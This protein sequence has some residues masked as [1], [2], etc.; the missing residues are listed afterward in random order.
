MG[1]WFEMWGLR[2]SVIDVVIVEM[3]IY[4]ACDW[5]HPYKSSLGDYK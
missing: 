5:G 4:P 1:L 3:E 2:F